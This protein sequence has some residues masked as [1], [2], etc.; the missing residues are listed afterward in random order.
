MIIV[1]QFTRLE[2]IKV[3][4]NTTSISISIVILVF[5]LRS[6]IFWIYFMKFIIWPSV[7][8]LFLGRKTFG[9]CFLVMIFIFQC[10]FMRWIW[11]S[12]VSSI[13]SGSSTRLRYGSWLPPISWIWRPRWSWNGSFTIFRSWPWSSPISWF[14]RPRGIWTF[15]IKSSGIDGKFRPMIWWLQS[16]L[17]RWRMSRFTSGW[18]GTSL[19]QFRVIFRRMWS[20]FRRSFDGSGAT[21]RVFSFYIH[22]WALILRI[23]FSRGRFWWITVSSWLI[24]GFVIPK[25]SNNNFIC[26]FWCKEYK[27]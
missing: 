26:Y 13:W 15:S 12:A 17:W 11:S 19:R 9:F 25:I 18:F 27:F 3:L 23:F 1:L 5:S 7:L 2:N 21:L 16:P 10:M 4:Y 24:F 20:A 8:V 14:Q 22:W 6:S